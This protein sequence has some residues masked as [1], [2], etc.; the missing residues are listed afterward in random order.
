MTFTGDYFK[1]VQ[2]IAKAMDIQKI[3]QLATELAAL[4]ERKG[5]LFVLGVGGSAAN[6]SHAVND[7]RKLCN[8]EAHAPTDNVAYLT[9]ITN[10]DGW[11]MFFLEWLGSS[12][13][14]SKDAILILSVGGGNARKKVSVGL[15][16]AMI[17]A[18][19]VNA[20][21]FGIVGRS[22]GDTYKMADLCIC[23]PATI[24]SASRITPHSEAFQSVIW[25]SLVS[26]PIL[27]L[28]PTKW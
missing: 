22:D 7:F 9:A 3:D 8:I 27:Q 25:H 28:R 16:L 10:D 12:N 26:N 5:R 18:R 15:S 23:V 6:A 14:N 17:L 20:N 21:I 11:K 1:E 19:R 2:A 24:S 13:L 4:R